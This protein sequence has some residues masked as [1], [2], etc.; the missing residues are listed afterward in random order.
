MEM[1]RADF[2]NLIDQLWEHAIDSAALDVFAEGAEV[3][4]GEFGINVEE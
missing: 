1:T 2:E 4:M 3:I